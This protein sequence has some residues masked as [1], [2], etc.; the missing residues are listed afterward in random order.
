MSKVCN[1]TYIELY[2]NNQ[3]HKMSEFYL[4]AT[5]RLNKQRFFA[6]TSKTDMKLVE[7]NI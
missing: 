1:V 4:L 3:F 5:N 7:I 2:L 6:V